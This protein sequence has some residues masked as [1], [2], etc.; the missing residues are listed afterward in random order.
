[1]SRID[2]TKNFFDMIGRAG[3]KYY[4]YT[5][6]P[7]REI[8]YNDPETLEQESLANSIVKKNSKSIILYIA[9]ILV[10]ATFIFAICN[11][12]DMR[13]TIMLFIMCIVFVVVSIKDIK[14]GFKK[15]Q[16]MIGKVAYKHMETEHTSGSN[17]SSIRRN[18][19]PMVSVIPDGEEKI[20]YRD[21]RISKSDY[22]KVTEG[23]PVMVVNKG[24]YA[25]VIPDSMK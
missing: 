21:I 1:M 24:P 7:L 19:I 23:S 11:K 16:I 22:Y 15:T 9:T 8:V 17:T 12:S 5:P 6:K 20:I 13:A 3:A 14:A 4:D 2:K 25:G 18:E 10:I